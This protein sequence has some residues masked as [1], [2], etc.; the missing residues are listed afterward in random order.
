VSA[1]CLVPAARPPRGG[2]PDRAFLAVCATTFVASAGATVAWCRSM[3]AMGGMPMPGGWEMSMAW[4]RMP[5]QTWPGAA[6]AFVG[7]WALMMAAM[8][9]PSLVPSLLRYRRSLAGPTALVG[10]GYL[11]VWTVFGI[12]VYPIGVGLAEAA[13]AWDAVSRLVPAATALVVVLAGAVQ[14]TGWKAGRLACCRAPHP[15]ANAWRHGVRLGLD[16]VVCCAGPTAVLLALGVMD[17]GVMAIVTLA[18]SIERLAGLHA[19]RVSGV[20]AIAFGLFL[21]ARAVVPG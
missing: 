1:V 9:L 6:A 4:M 8:M 14:L 18:I 5:G 11:A 20:A 12:A 19:A 13:M 21:V 10:L 17:V 2:S 15:P 7:M 16:C 3:A